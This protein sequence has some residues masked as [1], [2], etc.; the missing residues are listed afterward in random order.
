MNRFCIFKRFYDKKQYKKLKRLEKSADT[1][2]TLQDSIELLKHY[3][4][5]NPIRFNVKVQG[6]INGL[7]KLKGIENRYRILVN[8]SQDFQKPY[9]NLV[10]QRNEGEE[11]NYQDFDLIISSKKDFPRLIKIAKILGPMGKMPSFANG[12]VN[13]DLESILDMISESSLIKSDS[14]GILDI[15]LGVTETLF[16]LSAI[17]QKL[18]DMKPAKVER[19]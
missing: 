14:H 6:K 4:F 15:D 11:V 16:N 3:S 13:D 2:V 7:V 10:L 12:L 1:R 18:L 17:Y 8:S 5:A 19:N 9:K